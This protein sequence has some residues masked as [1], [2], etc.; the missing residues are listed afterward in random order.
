LTKWINLAIF[1]PYIIIWAIFAIVYKISINKQTSNKFILFSSFITSLAWNGSKFA[2]IKY[3]FYNKTYTSIYGSFSILLFFL[4]WIYISW[5]I[6]LYGFKIYTILDEKNGNDT[7]NRE[8]N[9]Y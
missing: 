1:L 6:F 3:T 7:K 8:Q 2:F 9:S 4:L 5:I